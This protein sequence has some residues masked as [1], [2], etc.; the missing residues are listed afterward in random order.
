MIF[1]FLPPLIAISILSAD[2]AM[3]E[4]VFDEKTI[5]IITDGS[6]RPKD[7]KLMSSAL[8]LEPNG[9]HLIYGKTKEMADYLDRKT[10]M[11]QVSKDTSNYSEYVGVAIGLYF[12]RQIEPDLNYHQVVLITDHKNMHGV[13]A[14]RAT[15]SLE[16]CH[17]ILHLVPKNIV[18]Y[19]VHSHASMIKLGLNGIHNEII[20]TITSEHWYNPYELVDLIM[21]ACCEAQIKM[22]PPH[23]P[24]KY[25]LADI[26]D[27]QV[28]PYSRLGNGIAKQNPQVPSSPHTG[29][30]ILWNT[31]LRETIAG[32]LNF[33][34]DKVNTFA[35]Q[36]GV[37]GICHKYVRDTPHADS[38]YTESVTKIYSRH[39]IWGK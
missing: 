21:R 29:F 3:E 28:S 9:T 23:D 15:K 36:D 16:I 34:A 6:Y 38:S 39:G 11:S 30:V 2:K 19:H 32:I 27:S 20:H 4:E 8:I 13:F 22:P 25:D 10:Q 24:V 33:I 26:K 37:A 12:A 14:G 18:I 31:D 1:G 7:E 35:I 17:L 5:F